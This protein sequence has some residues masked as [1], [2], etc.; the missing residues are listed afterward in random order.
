MY[1]ANN[2][3][4]VLAKQLQT[5]RQVALIREFENLKVAAAISGFLSPCYHRRDWWRRWSRT[6]RP[7]IWQRPSHCG[8]LL[9]ELDF[10]PKSWSLIVEFLLEFVDL[11][12]FFLLLSTM[13]THISFIFRGYSYNPYIRGLKPSFFMV[14]GSKGTLLVFCSIIFSANLK[15]SRMGFKL[16]PFLGSMGHKKSRQTS[17]SRCFEETHFGRWFWMIGRGN[18]LGKEKLK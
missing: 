15:Q 5:I 18:M 16:D 9:R 4:Y 2:Y 11:V 8:C 14:L 17:L 13:K 1:I 10:L 6:W 3:K 12:F 7:R